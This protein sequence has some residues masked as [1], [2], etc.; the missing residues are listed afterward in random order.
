[1]I[2]FLLFFNRTKRKMPHALPHIE[3]FSWLQYYDTSL[4]F[5][6]LTH[7]KLIEF[8]Y[9]FHHIHVLKCTWNSTWMVARKHGYT[10]CLYIDITLVNYTNND[11]YIW[12]W[13]IWVWCSFMKGNRTQP[14][15]HDNDV[16]DVWKCG[17]HRRSHDESVERTEN[18]QWTAMRKLTTG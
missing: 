12:E 4:L 10:E 15:I 5:Y 7:S 13:Y 3:I 18:Q 14:F 16:H 8:F 17:H 11:I 1:M 6:W 9:K 2:F